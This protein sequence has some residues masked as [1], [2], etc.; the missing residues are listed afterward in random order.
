VPSEVRA[1]VRRRFDELGRDAFFADLSQRDEVSAT[2]LSPSDTQRLL[3]A[4]DVLEATGRP[5]SAWQDTRGEP[6]LAGLRTA[7]FVISPSREVLQERI[8]RRLAAMT[9]AGALDM[10]VTALSGID[11]SLPAAK[12]L[13]LSQFARYLAGQI[14]LSDAIAETDLATRQYAKR[15]QT[16]FRNRMGVWTWLHDAGLS[17]IVACMETEIS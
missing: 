8:A 17:N 1:R 13:G 11:P 5:L 14:S 2:R 3:R 9:T 15:Q 16:W 7:R 4:A 6:P 12:A 10:E